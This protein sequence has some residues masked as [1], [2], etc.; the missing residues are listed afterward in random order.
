M[1]DITQGRAGDIRLLQGNEAI[2]RGALEAGVNVVAAYP[3]TPSSEIPETL[4]RVAAERGLY[5]EWSV[6]EK[7]ALEVAAA[8]SYSGLRSLSAMKQVG[9]N[10][11]SDFLLHL[12]QY[13]T[14]G[15]MI[16]ILMR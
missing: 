1:S 11:A 13:G 10:V 16:L 9:V 15:A 7:V 3:G 2:A 6:N 12:A 14:R 5:V 4:A 8:A